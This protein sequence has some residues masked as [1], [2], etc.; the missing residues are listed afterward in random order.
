ME[1]HAAARE[2][3]GGRQGRRETDDVGPCRSQRGTG[4][5]L[6]KGAAELCGQAGGDLHRLQPPAPPV[7]VARCVAITQTP[8]Q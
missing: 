4:T 2:R 5:T 1:M 3:A 7:P 8:R 6:I